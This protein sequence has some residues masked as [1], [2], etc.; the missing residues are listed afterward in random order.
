MSGLD[1]LEVELRLV[2][3]TGARRSR[4]LMGNREF[5]PST[6]LRYQAKV[7]ARDWKRCFRQ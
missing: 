5:F 6:P 4:L 1:L 3:S 2:M 7:Q